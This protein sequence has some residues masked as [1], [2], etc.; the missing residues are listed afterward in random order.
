[1]VFIWFSYGF[2]MVFPW[3]SP[4]FPVD[5]KTQRIRHGTL[6]PEVGSIVPWRDVMTLTSTPVAWHSAIFCT[7]FSAGVSGKI[8]EKV[9]F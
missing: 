9:H 7:G 2:H 1:M 4:D 3:F 8:H 6:E 5:K